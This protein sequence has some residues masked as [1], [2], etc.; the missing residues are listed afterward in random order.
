MRRVT[1]KLL[2]VV[3]PT[4]AGLVACA[5]LFGIDNGQLLDG[6]NDGGG[7]DA[8]AD[9]GIDNEVHDAIALDVNTAVC[10]GGV[11][12]VSADA[13][14]W[15]SATIGTDGMTC[16][17]QSQP[18]ATIANAI[19]NRNGRSVVYLDNS[20]FNEAV[21]LGGAQ[22]SLTIQGGWLSDAGWT[23]VCD[24]GTSVIQ[25]PANAGNAGIEI[26]NASGVTLR[27][28]TVRS[29]VQ[30]TN[31]AAESVYAARVIDSTGTTLD[32]VT[33]LSQFGGAGA[34]G[35][36]PLSNMGCGSVAGSGTIGVNGS[37]GGAGTFDNNGFL[38]RAGGDASAGQPGSSQPGTP[39][40]CNPCNT[41]CP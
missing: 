10:D 7:K 27:L 21:V 9:A 18:C 32:N 3:V 14:V 13:A 36:T 41:G 33:L 12:I 6:G 39:G 30:G 29:K 35:Q 15:V 23:A 40:P 20:V 25:Q 24:N 4:L 11:P 8:S 2:A 26:K 1:W 19:S 34:Q 17:D 37:A 5:S 31:G 22:A 16:G 28:L 38:P